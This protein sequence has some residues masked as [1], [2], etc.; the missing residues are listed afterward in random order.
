MCVDRVGAI[1]SFVESSTGLVF[2]LSAKIS[3]SHFG[4]VLHYIRPQTLPDF[5]DNDLK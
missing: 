5:A 4:F 2:G 3:K 1:E